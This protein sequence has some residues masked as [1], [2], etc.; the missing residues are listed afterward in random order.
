MA[1]NI[2]LRVTSGGTTLPTTL[3]ALTDVWTITGSSVVGAV[4][5]IALSV[6]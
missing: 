5:I 2:L 6:G 3:G 1:P 4:P